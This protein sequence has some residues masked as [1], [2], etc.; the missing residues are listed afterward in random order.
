M[1]HQCEAKLIAEYQANIELWKHDD[2][3]RQ[4][5]QSNF[6]TLNTILFVGLGAV[7]GF[8]PS[9]IHLGIIMFF[10]S[11]FGLLLSIIWHKVQVRNAEYV[12]FRRFQLQHI[13][14]KLGNIDT[15]TNTYNAFY[16]FKNV[17][18]GEKISTFILT[19]QAKHR[20]TLSE[21]KLPTLI[22]GFW[23][24]SAMASIILIVIKMGT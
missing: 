14:S 12:R 13:E 21:G 10:F 3:L 9:I 6:L 24:V 8:K 16:N 5:R 4:Q 18:F 1:E 15:F 2:T 11:L 19:E 23:S 20:S 7:A 22:G 17:D